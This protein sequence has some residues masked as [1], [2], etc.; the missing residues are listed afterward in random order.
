MATMYLQAQY[1]HSPAR[2][3]IWLGKILYSIETISKSYVLS[4]LSAKSPDPACETIQFPFFRAADCPVETLSRYF[5]NLPSFQSTSEWIIE[6]SVREGCIFMDELRKIN[7]FSQRCSTKDQYLFY[8][9]SCFVASNNRDGRFL[10]A[11]HLFMLLEIAVAGY[12]LD[13]FMDGDLM[14]FTTAEVND[15]GKFVSKCFDHLDTT[16]GE[17]ANIERS[18]PGSP[19]ECTTHNAKKQIIDFIRW[20][21]AKRASDYDR[22]NLENELKAA[23]VAHISHVTASHQLQE[24]NPRSNGCQILPLAMR[25]QTYYHWL[26]RSASDSILYP[27]VLKY[28]ICHCHMGARGGDTDVFRSAKE[29]YIIEDI[30]RH[31]AAEARL[32]NDHGSVERDRKEGILNSCAFLELHA[33]STGDHEVKSNRQGGINDILVELARYENRHVQLCLDEFE[34]ASE[35][36]DHQDLISRVRM[37]QLVT[38]VW[39]EM[40]SISKF[41]AKSVP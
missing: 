21:L 7:F 35:G 11:K 12:Q 26:R 30:C 17:F 40:Y 23:L 28:M 4:A 25:R 16:D 33:L 1:G 38:Q 9:A 14:R 10:S 19:C 5:S 32:W 37:F 29:K 2:E 15:I 8:I 20:M 22:M 13:N 24:S 36:M 3:R 31:A 6:S 39:N 27:L 18:T 41:D 34:R